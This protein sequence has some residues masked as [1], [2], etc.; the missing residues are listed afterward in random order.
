MKTSKIDRQQDVIFPIEIG[1]DT[2]YTPSI[3]EIHR[4]G[5]VLSLAEHARRVFD[6]GRPASQWLHTVIILG[7]IRPMKIRCPRCNSTNNYIKEALQKHYCRK[8]GCLWAIVVD[9]EIISLTNNVIA[10]S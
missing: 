1:G 8:C 2:L 3:S 5:G 4:P 9:S 7:G 10:R 6:S